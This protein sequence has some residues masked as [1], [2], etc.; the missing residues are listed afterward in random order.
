MIM[1]DN[2]VLHPEIG[3]T[4]AQWHFECWGHLYD[5]WSKAAAV[6]EF[7]VMKHHSVPMTLV[8]VEHTDTE[9]RVVG[10][11]SL[12]EDDDLPGFGH[13]TPWL[14]SLFVVPEARGK[15]VGEQLILAIL[16]EAFRLHY[17]SV[18]LFTP[19]NQEYFEQRGWQR[20]TEAQAH[21][22][23]VT[24]MSHSSSGKLI[25]NDGVAEKTQ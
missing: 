21:G 19:D 22:H 5:N 15:G 13:L 14:G 1:I 11:V 16:S 9:Y 17:R 25:A 23:S 20:V 8:A 3:P 10:S 4:L 24:V 12:F 7:A 6:Q 2:I 18:Y